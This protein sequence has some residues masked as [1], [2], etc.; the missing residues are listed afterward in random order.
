MDEISFDFSDYKT[1]LSHKGKINGI[2]AS[3]NINEFI[4][5]LKSFEDSLSKAKG[6]LMNFRINNEQSALIINDFMSKVH[7]LIN[8]DTEVIFSTEQTKDIEKDEITYQIIIT[9]L[10]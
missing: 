2:V 3:C 8:E 1:I 6:V 4:M 9:G 10:K 7:D 5:S